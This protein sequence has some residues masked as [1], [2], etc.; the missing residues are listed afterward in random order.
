MENLM[1][2]LVAVPLAGGFLMPLVGRLTGPRRA[3]AILPIVMAAGILVL[4]LG[5]LFRSDPTPLT[6]WMGAWRFPVGISLVADGLSKLVLLVIAVISLLALLFSMDYMTRYT[7]PGL[8][9]SLFML[10]LAGMNGVVL[11]G[12]LFNLFVFLEI[13]S[14][15]SYA[16]VA[17]GTEADELEASF[18]YL[19]LGAIASVFVLVGIAIVYNVT[20]HLNLAKIAE[21]LRAGGGLTVPLYLAAAFFLMGF[22]L[23]AA[24]VP[25]H[26]WLPDAHPSAPAPISAMLSGVLIKACGVYVLCRLVFSVFGNHEAFGVILVVMGTLSMVL[27]ALMA[28]GQKDLKR[29]LAYSSISQVGYVVTAIGA[30]VVSFAWSTSEPALAAVAA[31]ALFGGF[32]HLVNHAIFKSLLFLCSGS[33]EHATGTRLLARLGGLGQRMPVTGWSLRAGAL[34]ISGVP[35]F[36]GFWSKLIIIVALVQAAALGHWAFYVP[37]VLAVAVAVVTLVYYAKVQRWVLGGEPSAATADA[38][39]APLG[40]TVAMALLA[41]LSLASAAIIHPAVKQRLIDPATKVLTAQGAEASEV[42]VPAAALTEA[43]DRRE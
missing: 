9:Y 20:G 24:M 13:A 25:F 11:A 3:A 41:V 18:K 29:L 21:V 12:D 28:I 37:A 36:G 1:P 33:V 8:Y 30:G 40:M 10:M 32:F 34:A 39:E 31:L 14:I 16:L 26:A 19:V 17:F 42:G 15:A 23:K 6:Y 22:G 5:L 4:A 7:S 38:R 43:A 2:L 35:P 27:G